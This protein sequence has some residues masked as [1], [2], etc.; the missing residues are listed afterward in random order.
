VTKRPRKIGHN[1]FTKAGLTE[2]LF[3]LYGILLTETCKAVCKYVQL[4]EIETSDEGQTCPLVRGDAKR[5][6]SNFQVFRLKSS[7]KP[8]EGLGVKSWTSTLKMEAA[9]SSETHPRSSYS[10]IA[11]IGHKASPDILP[12]RLSPPA[13]EMACGVLTKAPRRRIQAMQ[14]HAATALND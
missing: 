5:R 6:L 1:L 3:V 10:C 2:V 4:T 11:Y 14:R 13:A 9:G 8:R 7:H 12:V